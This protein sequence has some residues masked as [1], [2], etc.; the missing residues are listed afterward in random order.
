MKLPKV[1][2]KA[3][4]STLRH[5]KSGLVSSGALA[6]AV[7]HFHSLTGGKFVIGWNWAT[8]MAG[9]ISALV[10]LVT[11]GSQVLMKKRPDLAPEITYADNLVNKEI[12][13]VTATELGAAPAVETLGAGVPT[14]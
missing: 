14:A 11:V 13:V 10:A 9:A 8:L 1:N 2:V 3:L 12:K 6:L 4:E 7:Q 5:W